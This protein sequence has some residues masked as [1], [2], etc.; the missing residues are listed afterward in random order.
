MI[1][2]LAILAAVGIPMVTAFVA[3]AKKEAANKNLKNLNVAVAKFNQAYRELDSPVNSG[4]G[5]EESAIMAL[6]YRNPA[7]PVPGT[8]FLSDQMVAP[9]T[10]DSGV[11]RGRWNGRMFE[12]IEIGDTGT[13]INLLEM[14]DGGPQVQF[15]SGYKPGQF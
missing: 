11:F 5:D 4:G 10:S 9:I 3:G 1:A 2:I 6:Q 15:P 12:I 7:N 14:R 13:G 8:P